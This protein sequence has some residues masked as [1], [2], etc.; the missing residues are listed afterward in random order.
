MYQSSVQWA[1]LLRP[2]DVGQSAK[3]L[4]G[5]TERTG[6]HRPTQVNMALSQLWEQGVAGSNPAFPTTF[7]R[8]GVICGITLR[9]VMGRAG[10]AGLRRES[11]WR[12][13][14]RRS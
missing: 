8:A 1:V 2:A 7:T 4:L 11:L 9:L 3:L 6:P 10:R 13:W 12:V 14:R 5:S